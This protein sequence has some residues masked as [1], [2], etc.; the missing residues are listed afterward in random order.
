MRGVNQQLEVMWSGM[1]L[2]RGVSQDHPLRPIQGEMNAALIHM[3]SWFSRTCAREGRL[4]IPSEHLLHAGLLP[5]LYSV[6]R[7]RMLADRDVADLRR[8]L[9]PSFEASGGR[10]IGS[11]PTSRI[12]PSDA[13]L[14]SI[15]MLPVQ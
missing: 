8:Q 12:P 3:S 7:A 13:L 10:R 5:M 14:R 2:V 15:T 9:S 11:T 1:S 4:L 6:R